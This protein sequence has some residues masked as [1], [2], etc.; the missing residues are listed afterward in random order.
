MNS[1]EY[2][3]LL[4]SLRNAGT[5]ESADAAR[6]LI[7]SREINWSL[8]YDL[9]DYHNIRPQLAAFLAGSLQ[10]LVPS[11]IT[12]RFQDTHRQNLVAQID[13]VSEFFRVARWLAAEGI[14]VVPFKGFWL[15][16]NYYGNLAARESD[17]I[18]VLVHFDDLGKI[19]EIMPETGYWIGAPY[20]QE[21]NIHDCEFNY[22][23]YSGGRCISHFEFHWRIAPSGFGL[24][25]TLGD[26]ALRLV[27]SE[28]QGQPLQVFD[29]SA[30][31]LLTVMHHGGKDGF[32]KLKQVYDIAM[33]LRREEEIDWN[34]LLEEAKRFGCISLLAV[35]AALASMITGAEVPVALK[36]EAGSERIR[37][38]ARDRTLYL[39]I[40]PQERRMWRYEYRDWLFRVKSRDGLPVRLRLIMR[41]VRK[42]FI[43]WMIP[44]RLHPL[45]MRRYIIPDY[46]K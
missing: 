23:L 44:Q 29:P 21:V 34:W 45:F 9:A 13:H 43:P 6:E 32:A 40:T 5:A 46:A 39:T 41:F 36:R 19:R 2:E 14:T 8:V 42:V 15:A 35:S 20:L 33:I 10:D 17:D 38:L 30:T 18:D 37:N 11:A 22:G 25:I 7:S 4:F 27:S 12:E 28:V 24:D 16:E 1:P 26:L 31:L 3:L